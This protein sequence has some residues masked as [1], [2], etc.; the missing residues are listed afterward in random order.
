MSASRTSRSCWPSRPPTPWRTAA[1]S[2]SPNCATRSFALDVPGDN[3]DYDN[4]V[5]EACRRGGFEPRTHVS[6][7]FH[8]SWEGAVRSEGCVGFTVRTSLHAAHRDLRLLTLRE[9][10]TFPIDLIWRNPPGTLRPT[11]DAL[12]TTA[13]EIG[14]QE[15]TADHE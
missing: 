7:A 3:P 6:S 9:P 4:A 5:V 10:L 12:L 8:D 1:R 14:R 11:L 2:R 15:R 13:R